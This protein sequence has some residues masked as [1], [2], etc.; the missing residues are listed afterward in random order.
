M[1]NLTIITLPLLVVAFLTGCT[2]PAEQETQAKARTTSL[3]KAVR[4]SKENPTVEEEQTMEPAES[5][6]GEPERR[7]SEEK[8]D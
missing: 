2:S 7:E 5:V 1:K 3:A 4:H 8:D 6:T